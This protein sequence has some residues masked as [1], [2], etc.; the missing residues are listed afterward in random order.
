MTLFCTLKM[1]KQNFP[2]LKPNV[3]AFSSSASASLK[4][5]AERISLLA[6]EYLP[7]RIFVYS[8]SVKKRARL[9]NNG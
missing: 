6:S 1:R 4:N 8:R 3:A 5:R 9:T 2:K 7:L